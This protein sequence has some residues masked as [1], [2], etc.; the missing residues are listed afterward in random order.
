[1][2]VAGQSGSRVR[3]EGYDAGQLAAAYTFVA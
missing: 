2:S 1:V 3:I